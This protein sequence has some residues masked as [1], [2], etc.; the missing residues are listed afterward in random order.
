MT[1][2][3][4]GSESTFLCAIPTFWEGAG[5]LVDFFDSLSQFNVSTTPEAADAKALH[6]DWRA[7]GNDL[8]LALIALAE[9]LDEPA[10]QLHL[11]FPPDPSSEA[12]EGLHSITSSS[13]SHRS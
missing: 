7:V 8:H 4:R 2:Q 5:R 11:H 6:N 1:E 9:E 3:P 10:L 13:I 12:G